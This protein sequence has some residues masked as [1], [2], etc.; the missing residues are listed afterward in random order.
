ML[1]RSEGDW[2]R[3][4]LF[5]VEDPAPEMRVLLVQSTQFSSDDFAHKIFM[6][7]VTDQNASVRETVYR[8]ISR[9]DASKYEAILLS[10][11]QDIN[12]SAQLAAIKS[13][14]WSGLEVDTMH[15]SVFLVHENPELRLHS[16]RAIFRI[17]P[18]AAKSLPQLKALKDDS[19][20]KVAREAQRIAQ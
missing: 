10:G 7:L 15:L 18:E 9:K 1:M 8:A 19:N 4:V 6:T 20:P 3:G 14:G 17:D 2:E 16:L 12:E 11:L 5:L 13:I